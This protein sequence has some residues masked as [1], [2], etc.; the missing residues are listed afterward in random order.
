MSLAGDSSTHRGHSFFDLHVHI[1]FRG[2]LLN[3]HLVAIPMFDRHTA[4]NIFN[5]L[6]KFVDTL[7]GKWC[8]KLIGMSSDDKNMMTGRHTGFITRMIAY[9]ENPVFRI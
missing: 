4:S 7:Y 8:A 2:R 3:L 5:M 6:V 1:C 9:A